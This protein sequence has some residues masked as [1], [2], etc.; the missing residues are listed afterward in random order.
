MNDYYLRSQDRATMDA[1]LAA[2]GLAQVRANP[3][4]GPDRTCV[5][6]GVLI[7]HIGPADGNASH[8]ANLR[9][10]AA[11]DGAQLAALPIIPPP[12]TP[13]REWAE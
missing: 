7:D 13:V 4:G 9:T 10:G 1:A 2:A 8:H 6:D 12:A 11:L 5:V 3:A